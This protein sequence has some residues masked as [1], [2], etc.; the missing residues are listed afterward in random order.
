MTNKER[1]RKEINDVCKTMLSR[2]QK[3][4]SKAHTALTTHDL[5]LAEEV[6]HTENYVNSLNLKIDKDCEQFLALYNPVAVDLR[7]ITAVR[8]INS[9][10]ERIGD[11]AYA[12][13]Q[14]VA[15]NE[16]GI[17]KDI[18]KKL[19]YHE[20]YGII[21][22][23]FDNVIDSY[24][25]KNL[26]IARKVFKKDKKVNKINDKVFLQIEELIKKD[27][28]SIKDCLTMFSII[29]KLERV[30][31]LIKN[32]AEDIIFYV[33]AEVVRHQVKK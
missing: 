16:K 23:M 20:M 1:Y 8:N 14:Y 17:S 15:Q 26:K 4:L 24:E 19:S 2:C 31:D 21:E 33:D 29:K 18:L 7:F 32:I 6:M 13:A 10:L 28:K 27:A 9:E 3:Q 5:D 25:D 22:D 12:I 11:H 30:G